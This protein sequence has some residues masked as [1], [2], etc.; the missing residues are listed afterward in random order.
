[1]DL[2][3]EAKDIRHFHHILKQ[4][5]HLRYINCS[6]NQLTEIEQLVVIQNLLVLNASRNAF[7]SLKALNDRASL[8]NL[9]HLNLSN[10]KI[11]ALTALCLPSLKTL[12]LNDN[13]IASCVDF[14]G[15]YSIEI[16]QM[17]RNKLTSL[18]GLKNMTSLKE[19][20]LA[21]NE[22]TSLNHLKAMLNL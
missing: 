15:H 21:E 14:K 8:Q 16:L 17:R 11:T 9:E 4:Y 19:L 18:A 5:P 6:K 2:D 1:M 3:V 22:I 13:Q 10:N 20:Y 12:N 7:C